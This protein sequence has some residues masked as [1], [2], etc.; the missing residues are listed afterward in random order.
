MQCDQAGQ[1]SHLPRSL[2]LCRRSRTRKAAAPTLD[3]TRLYHLEPHTEPDPAEIMI[4]ADEARPPV[5]P[6]TPT[7]YAPC[8]HTL[9]PPL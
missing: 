9:V 3:E 8:L 1:T 2:F 5:K 6:D 7:T 4:D